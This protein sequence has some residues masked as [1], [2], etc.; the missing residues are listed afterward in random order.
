MLRTIAVKDGSN[1]C[2]MVL[3]CTVVN[4]SPEMY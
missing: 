3:E 2:E 1:K 4:D